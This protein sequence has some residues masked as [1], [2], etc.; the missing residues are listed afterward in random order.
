M[1]N[2]FCDGQDGV[3]KWCDL[4]AWLIIQRNYPTVPH[5]FLS[6]VADSIEHYLVISETIIVVVPWRLLRHTKSTVCPHLPMDHMRLHHTT[7]PACCTGLSSCRPKAHM[8][9]LT[10]LCQS[11]LKSVTA[12]S[13]RAPVPSTHSTHIILDTWTKVAITTNVLDWDTHK[14]E[15]AMH[16]DTFLWISVLMCSYF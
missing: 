7:L 12:Q 15:D 16:M 14:R 8:H 9:K 3:L 1:P 5:S 6:V 10:K 11:L 2:E 4:L 13:T